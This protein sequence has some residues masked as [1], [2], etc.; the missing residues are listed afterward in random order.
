MLGYIEETQCAGWGEIR[1][2][3]NPSTLTKPTTLGNT[4]TSFP[5]PFYQPGPD[6]TM[7][8]RILPG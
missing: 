5:V 6:V 1:T 8:T 4:F 7:N 3:T 2:P